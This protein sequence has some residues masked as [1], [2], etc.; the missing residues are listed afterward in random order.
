[1]SIVLSSILTLIGGIALLI[2]SSFILTTTIEDI[3]KKG[4][5]T[6]SFTGTFI[7]P[8]F[9]SLAELGVILAAL[10]TLTPRS[11]SQIAAGIII[12]EPFMVSAIGFP[13]MAITLLFAA[14]K[15]S[16]AKMDG[17]MPLTLVFIGLSFPLMLIP[18]FFPSQFSRFSIVLLLLVIYVAVLYYYGKKSSPTAGDTPQTI[19]NNGLL[20][21]L[22]IVGITVLA[23]ASIFLVKSVQT[24]AY[25]TQISDQLISILIIPIG[26]I[27]PETLNSIIWAAESKTNLAMGAITGEEILFVTV[28]PALGIMASPWIINR[29]GMYAILVGSIF[30]ILM[31]LITYKFRNALYLYILWPIS[32]VAFIFLVIY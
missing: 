7:S 13:A 16:V 8:V 20:V 3:G 31:G 22:V 21:L 11:G 2:V 28:Y 6:H 12:G 30:F 17:I 5:F 4:K 14:R 15:G 24:I 29:N 1:M 18:V 32:I 25:Q 10:I 27:I 9:T 26:T 19:K 23:V